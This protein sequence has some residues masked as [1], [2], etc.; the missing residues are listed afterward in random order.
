MQ[1][2]PAVQFVA[3][4]IIAV[5]V[6]L[7]AWFGGSRKIDNSNKNIQEANRRDNNQLKAEVTT[8]MEQL[9]TNSL[10]DKTQIIEL[11]STNV[12][13]LTA[14]SELQLK[15]YN[16]QKILTE[17]QNERIDILSKDNAHQ[18]QYNAKLEGF[19]DQ[20]KQEREALVTRYEALLK[21]QG[22]EL[23]GK[24]TT[25]DAQN[26]ELEQLRAEVAE[27]ANMKKQ[28]AQLE[29]TVKRLEAEMSEERTRLTQR[30]NELETENQA[31]LQRAIRAETERDEAKALAAE[32]QQRATDKLPELTGEQAA[33][34]DGA[35]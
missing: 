23:T 33:K 26:T 16:D 34:L 27:I 19:L 24:Q 11:H 17:A 30:I 31:L 35:E 22:N 29:E 3:N 2:D 28:I 15:A 18:K 5:I 8:S 21:A 25:I 7:L 14:N 10:G 20:A 1:P 6:G 12:K 4:V 13:T 32:W 9:L